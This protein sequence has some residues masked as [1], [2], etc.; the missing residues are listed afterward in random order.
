MGRHP[1]TICD[2]C[3]RSMPRA[4]CIVDDKGYCGTC[5][6]RELRKVACQKCGRNV[7]V[8]PG[9][10]T[11]MC[12]TCKIKE[13]FCSGCGKPLPAASLVQG[14]KAYC[15]N[16]SRK[17]PDPKPCAR[18]GK[19]TIYLAKS[20]PR[21]IH[22]Y[23]CH[24]CLSK[25]SQG[26]CPICGKFRVL[27]RT[28]ENGRFIC[29]RCYDSPHFICPQ[30]KKPGQRH[31][32]SQCFACYYREHNGRKIGEWLQGVPKGWVKDVARKWYEE[33]MRDL[34]QKGAFLPMVRVLPTMQ[35]FDT[36]HTSFETPEKMTLLALTE[37]FGLGWTGRYRIGLSV[38]IELGF[39]PP[40]D[41]QAYVDIKNYC[42][43]VKM[44]TS[45]SD[46]WFYQLLSE[47]HTYMQGI[48][49][50][51]QQSGWSSDEKY[52][53]STIKG[54]VCA[55][56]HFLLSCE[57]KVERATDLRD[58]HFERFV[59]AYPG[60]RATISNFIFFLNYKRK[61]FK[62]ISLDADDSGEPKRAKKKASKTGSGA[63][64]LSG[65]AYQDLI[66]KLYQSPP[67]KARQAVVLLFALHYA[68]QVGKIVEMRL[69][70]IT[71]DEDGTF[72]VK[73]ADTPIE[74]DEHTAKVLAMYM[75]QRHVLEKTFKVANPYLF[76][77]FAIGSHL[78]SDS[79][80]TWFRDHGVTVGQ[81][82]ATALVRLFQ[83]GVSQPKVLMDGLGITAPTA[84][85]YYGL[86]NVRIVD[87]L[88]DEK[89]KRS[90]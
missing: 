69:D 42:K 48:R 74:I 13:R 83:G 5:A 63:K 8:K 55:A 18:C 35:F 30:C 39:L 37:E 87:E 73:F 29:K 56:L 28:D 23:V 24:S 36:L 2:I 85:K 61:V 52:Q 68:Q 11:V 80:Q 20:A 1:R 82:Y 65:E 17:L 71:Q 67:S 7:R 77:G 10:T 19:V 75:H 43:Q 40:K 3:G 26:T 51:Y 60:Y 27:K 12:H 4:S 53:Q 79:T 88:L 49:E 45:V 6:K 84:M 62:P 46:R 90:I 50:R 47:Y 54:Y 86:A 89:A 9:M 64:A 38:L 66:A 41:D 78:E 32:A 76:P 57:M 70:A 15:F 21:G 72:Y 16:C 25:E 81:L 34:E 33:L 14:D 22:E 31:S 59:I 58:E 44:V